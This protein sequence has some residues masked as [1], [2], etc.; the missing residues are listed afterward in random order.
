M[1][2]TWITEPLSGRWPAE[3]VREICRVRYVS[4]VIASEMQRFICNESESEVVSD[5]LR[6]HGL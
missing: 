4:M 5:S 6:P 2:G 1:E 3:Y